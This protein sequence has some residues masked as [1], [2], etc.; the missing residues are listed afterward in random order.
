MS[1]ACRRHDLMLSLADSH[2]VA[3]LE[4]TIALIKLLPSV[5][6]AQ[7]THALLFCRVLGG[8]HCNDVA[9]LP[10]FFVISRYCMYACYLLA[11]GWLGHLGWSPSLPTHTF[12]SA[13][14]ALLKLFL[15]HDARSPLIHMESTLSALLLWKLT[16][17]SVK[18]QSP[19]AEIR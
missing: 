13:S 18:L 4:K 19:S 7:A 14:P 16:V 15:Q 6:T 2:P 9:S 5:S 3:S 1:A 8:K 17:I 10:R 11:A 12:F